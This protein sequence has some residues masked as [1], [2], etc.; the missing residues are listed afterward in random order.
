[1]ALRPYQTRAVA[2]VRAAWEVGSHCVCLVAPTGAG[3]SVMGAELLT[4]AR[5]PLV[6]THTRVLRDQAQ[7]RLPAVTVRTV[8]SLLAESGAAD[9]RRGELA[10]HD[11][12]W[13]DE[14]HHLASDEWRQMMPLL[15]HCRIVGT[16]ATPQRADGTPLGD[17]CDALVVA[18]DY[19]E[20]LLDGHLCPCDVAESQL[21]RRD[22]RARK[23][24]PDGVSAYL[25]LA[26]RPDGSWRPGVH[27][28]S[29]IALCQDASERYQRSGVRACVVSCE[30]GDSDRQDL[31]DRYTAGELDMLCSPMALSEGFDSPRAEV[32]VARRTLCHVGTYLQWAGRILRPH[33]GKERALLIDITNAAKV[34]GLPTADR[35]YSLDGKGIRVKADVAAEAEERAA[36]EQFAAVETKYQLVRDL[37]LD[38]WLELSLQCKERGYNIGWVRHRMR[39]QLGAEPPR[40]FQAKWSSTCNHCRHKLT[41]GH[42]MFWAP[43]TATDK[44]A[45]VW[46]QDCWFA[47]LGTEQIDAIEAHQNLLKGAAE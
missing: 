14:V 21:S 5:S 2:A 44:R 15:A 39:E 24:R 33:P 20:L 3:K 38:K 23:E 34:H 8:Q 29:T 36:L 7:R 19:S 4:A 31:F 42:P 1:M 11:L 40:Q 22:Q 17:V 13:I 10:G 6:I 18:A 16:T 47:S 9:R 27:C 28:E 25:S 46:H 12:V 30:T 43:P 37:L 32:L 41:P 35:V 26:A 45:R